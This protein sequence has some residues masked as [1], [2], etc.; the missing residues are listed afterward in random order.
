MAG[1][2]SAVL[3]VLFLSSAADAQ[4][5]LRD[6]ERRRAAAEADRQRLQSDVRAAESQIA[7][8]NR[9]RAEAESQR[10]AAASEV[11]VLEDITGRLGAE[12]RLAEARRATAGAALEQTLIALSL[13]HAADPQTAHVARLAG[14]ALIQRAALSGNAADRAREERRDLGVRRAEL[15]VAQA[16]LESAD[17]ALADAVLE[18]QARRALLNAQAT[19]ASRRVTALAEQARSLRALVARATRG[20]RTATAATP[21]RNLGPATAGLARLAPGSELARRFGARGAEGVTLRTAAGARVLAPSAAKVA[22]SGP[23]RSYGSVLILDPGGD[24]AIVL[25]GMAS[26]LVREGQTVQAGRPIAQMGLDATAAPE[27]YVEVRRNGEPVDPVTWLN[28]RR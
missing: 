7:T 20:P 12:E 8:L 17:A 24:C 18:Q 11:L 3:A 22:W 6:V 21:P 25:T 10:R 28:G 9:Q 16:R 15:A 1:A 19:Q 23:F 13:P 5:S 27:L 2:A 26:I 4:P 14:A